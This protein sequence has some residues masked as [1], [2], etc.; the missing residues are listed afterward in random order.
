MIK[1]AFK[2]LYCHLYLKYGLLY[3]KYGLGFMNIIYF[4]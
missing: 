3:L 4:C 2:L 1:H